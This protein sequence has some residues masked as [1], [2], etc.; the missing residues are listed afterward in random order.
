MSLS[1]TFLPTGLGYV[2]TLSDQYD[3]DLLTVEVTGMRSRNGSLYALLSVSTKMAGAKRLPGTDRVLTTELWILSERSRT[4]AAEA[5]RRL[6]PPPKGAQPIDFN[7]VLAEVCQ[8]VIDHENRPVD[9][10]SLAKSTPAPPTPWLID[11][12]LP[13]N[14]PTILYG[15]G[16]VGKSI[17]AAAVAVAIQAGVKHWLG[18]PVMQADVLYLDWETD[19]S[20]IASRIRAAANGLKVP[21]PDVQYASL[22]RPIEDRVDQL[23]RLVA[24]KKIGLVIIDS[25]GMAMSS[26][27]DGGDASETAIRFFRALRALNAAVLAI[28][29]VSGDDMRRGTAGAAKPYGSVY[30]WNSARNA[31][32]LRQRKDPDQ[33]GAH[34][35]MKHRKS[36]IGPRQPDTNVLLKWSSHEATFTPEHILPPT[37]DPLDQRI[38]DLLVVGPATPHRLSDLLSDDENYVGELAIRQVLKGLIGTQQVTVS[39]DGSIRL[40]S[41]TQGVVDS[42]LIPE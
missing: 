10:V 22:V 12:V 23:A 24:E 39:A 26:A 27:K 29:H 9:V 3:G 40:A 36:N 20:D 34:L 42:G 30:K 32:E 35:V 2:Y 41:K 18:Y 1:S 31:F 5:L 19:E 6:I 11:G 28:D 37:Q 38:M 25:V 16:G 33:D 4:D 14:R 13:C 21:V 8:R 17:F 7:A 15:A